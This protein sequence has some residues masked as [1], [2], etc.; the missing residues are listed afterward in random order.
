M[1]EQIPHPL[2]YSRETRMGPREKPQLRK[3][4][5]IFVH[6][7]PKLETMGMSISR[8]MD[9][10]N[11]DIFIRW[12]PIVEKKKSN[13][14]YTKSWLD[15]RTVMLSKIRQRQKG[16][17][18]RIPFGWNARTGQTNV[19]ALVWGGIHECIHRSRWMYTLAETQWTLHLRSVHVSVNFNS[20][21]KNGWSRQR[22]ECVIFKEMI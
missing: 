22:I 19:L 9:S 21:L 18:P 4:V 5:Y 10:A 16:I 1:T 3:N 15:P 11:C 20:I 12:N 14:H 13:G 2:I 6:N 17:Y 7:S 8:R